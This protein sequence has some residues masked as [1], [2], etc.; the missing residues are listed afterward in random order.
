VGVGQGRKMRVKTSIGSKFVIRI[1]VAITII[2][3]IAGLLF[4]RHQEQK[5]TRLLE[6]KVEQVLKQVVINLRNSLWEIDRKQVVAVVYSYLS[7]P[8]ILAMRV[9]NDLNEE[10]FFGKDPLTG[11]IVDLTRDLEQP[12]RYANIFTPAKQPQVDIVVE[13]QVVGT[14]SVVFSNRY[15]TSRVQ[16]ITL[17]VGLSLVL[18]I[19]VESLIIMFLVRQ[20]IIMPL[21]TVVSVA[22]RV[23]LGEFDLQPLSMSKE[24]RSQDEIGILLQAFRDMVVYLDG[25]ARVADSISHGDLGQTFRP[26]SEKDT[27]GYAFSNMTRYLSEL[28]NAATQIAEGDFTCDIEPKS[29][30]DVLGNAF[31]S[32]RRR[33]YESQEALRILNRELEERVK[34]R[35]QKLKLQ[36]IELTKAKEVAETANRAKSAFLANMSHELRTPLNAILGFSSMMRCEREL[37]EGQREKLDIINRSGEHLLTLLNNILEISRIEAGRVQLKAAPFD[38]GALIQDAMDLMRLRAEEKGLSLQLDKSS[39][40][41]RYINGDEARLRQVLVNLI[42]NAVKFTNVGGV[43]IRLKLQHNDQKHLRMEVED[44]GPGISSEDQEYLFK[45]FTQVGEP[46]TQGGSGLGLAI[47]RQFVKLMNGT[48]GV[49]STLGKGSIFSVNLPVELVDEAAIEVLKRPPEAGKVLRLAPD[50]PEWRILIVE[51]QRENQLLLSRLMERV[52]F[53]VKVAENGVQGVQLFK[54]WHPHF[55][56]M[57]RRMPVMDGMEATRRIREL[58]DGKAVKIVAVTASAFAEQR[59]EIL[60]GGMDD[61]V[62][63]PFR[64]D[65]LYS[66]LSKY[67]GVK[68]IYKGAPESQEKEKALTPEMLQVIPEELRSDLIAA[69]ETLDGER[70]DAIIQEIGTHDQAIQKTLSRLAMNFDYPAILKLFQK[71][72]GISQAPANG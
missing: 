22:K 52:G 40:F 65:E 17:A 27:L 16:E 18:L 33:L 61:Y 49:S 54:S 67:L 38:L 32:M 23:S 8:D 50:Q 56:W 66:A 30:S 41:P 64:A 60:E 70:I 72:A 51:D 47:S 4:I 2:I 39:A 25:M 3:V 59:K 20:N 31:H 42:G 19:I 36:T 1:T 5:F 69:L 71:G 62:R 37:A 58:P 7:D 35:T 28:A 6:N 68:Y 55:I 14:C 15:I 44:T 46:G 24:M 9:V 26:L 53:M 43:T 48:I 29:E 63:K 12:I 21:N 57:D 10:V 34:E 13:E 45:P 11:A